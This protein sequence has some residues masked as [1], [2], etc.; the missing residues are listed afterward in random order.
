LENTPQAFDA[1]LG[2]RRVRGDVGDA[3]LLEGAAKLSGFALASKLLFDGPMVIFANEDAVAVSVEGQRYAEAR[4]Q[5]A[6]QVE[7]AF[8]G[9]G[10]EES[11]GKN[12]PGGIVLNPQ[13]G[14]LGATALEPV[15]RT[16]IEQ[17]DFAL[18]SRTDTALAMGWRRLRGGPRLEERSR[19][20]KV[21][22]LSEKASCSV[23]FS[24]RW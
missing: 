14:Q 2:L 17:D 18:A 11:G 24:W 3:K 16:A 13:G 10:G 12:L 8:G 4:K 23:S 1:T 5:A 7:I 15:M 9:L 21:S 6:Q 22:R 20:R 19:R